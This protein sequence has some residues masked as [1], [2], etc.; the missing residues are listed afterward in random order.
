MC[1]NTVIHT[2]AQKFSKMGEWESCRLSMKLSTH[3]S[4]YFNMTGCTKL[5]VWCSNIVTVL[6]AFLVITEC[7]FYTL[8][9]HTSL[10]F[11]IS[12]VS[13]H[14]ASLHNYSWTHIDLLINKQLL[15]CWAFICFVFPHFLLN[16]ALYSTQW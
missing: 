1:L 7:W 4:K 13:R 8:T 11:W 15:I 16:D 10:D 6:H 9:W 12:N 3:M 2:T 14:D 5:D